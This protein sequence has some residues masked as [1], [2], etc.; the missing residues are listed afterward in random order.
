[1]RWAREGLRQ[2]WIRLGRSVRSVGL[3]SK[4]EI[5]GSCVQDV[6]WSGYAKD[7]G[8]LDF[9][10]IADA[11]PLVQGYS[12]YHYLNILPELEKVASSL[13]N[14]LASRY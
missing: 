7:G 12:P 3:L 14:Q 10:P 2:G 1:M 4:K 5:K 11:I 8:Y 9:D 6:T 13:S